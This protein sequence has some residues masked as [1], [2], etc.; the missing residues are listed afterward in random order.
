VTG[1][2]ERLRRAEERLSRRPCPDCGGTP[3]GV[4]GLGEVASAEPT[5]PTCGRSA[6]VLVFERL[7][8]ITLE[9]AI[10]GDDAA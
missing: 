5:C 4:E 2:R 8:G 7:E 10:G 9:D 6:R 1:L 3:L